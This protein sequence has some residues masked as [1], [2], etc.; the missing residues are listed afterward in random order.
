MRREYTP[1]DLSIKED[2][3]LKDCYTLLEARRRGYEAI[4]INTKNL[5]TEVVM[6]AKF[7]MPGDVKQVEA[8]VTKKSQKTPLELPPFSPPFTRSRG[9]VL[10]A[11]NLDF[12]DPNQLLILTQQTRKRG[13]AAHQRHFRVL[14]TRS[15]HALTKRRNRLERPLQK[16]NSL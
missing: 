12:I 1:T 9:K 14:Q 4:R 5:R 7:V 6:P 11:D 16:P 13:P 15:A 8:S 2:E 10:N 3:D